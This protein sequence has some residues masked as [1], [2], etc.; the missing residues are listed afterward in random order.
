M[1]CDEIYELISLHI[2]G[3]TTP[4]Q[5]AALAAH[6][7]E[8]ESCRSLLRAYEDIQSGVADLAVDP[9]ERFAEGVMYRVSQEAGGNGGK[10]RRF[11]FGHA[12]AFAA[13][14][15][16]LVILVGTGLVKLPNSAES[17]DS[18][19]EAAYDTAAQMDDAADTTATLSVDETMKAERSSDAVVTEDVEESKVQF[20]APA[21]YDALYDAVDDAAEAET[22]DSCAD[23]IEPAV[24]APAA[25][26]QDVYRATLSGCKAEDI[27]ELA[28]L[29]Q[30]EADPNTYHGTAAQ[31][32][33]I[34]A[35]YR[36][37]YAADE[38]DAE[39]VPDD[40]PAVL[41]IL[42]E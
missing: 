20:S 38:S 25:D 5:E 8:C 14:A 16:A 24:E 4:E 18:A 6:L 26:E 13:V 42:P 19:P 11:A 28:E 21:S 37:T 34:I 15:A 39:G 10:M 7:A 1:S 17:A 36:E 3:E 31:V 23:S 2:D 32:R 12:T 30:D 41:T 27:P 29:T 22:A 33:E 40:A 9:P 35:A